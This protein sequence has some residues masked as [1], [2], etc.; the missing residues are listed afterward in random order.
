[1]GDHTL[2]CTS[3]GRYA[4]H[5]VIRDTLAHSL[6]G[7]GFSCRTEVQLPGSTLV[8]ADIFVQN[9]SDD[10]S[11]AVDVSVVHPLQ[12]SRSASAAVAA[13]TAAEERALAKVRD[14]EEAC[15]ARSWRFVAFVAE[16]TGAWNQAAQRLVRQ[17]V[18][19]HALRTGED[20]AAVAT[21]MWITLS[22]ALAQTVARQLVR[23]QAPGQGDVPVGLT[24]PDPGP[25][26]AK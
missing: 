24:A 21:S 3:S 16:S 12:P 18:R 14:Y 10:P 5:N 4:R 19:A 11:T 9:L 15:Q 8:P 17:A 6:R 1:M 7:F 25:P 2:W 26:W 22:R 23:A 13:G 20:S